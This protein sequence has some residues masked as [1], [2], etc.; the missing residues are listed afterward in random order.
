MLLNKDLLELYGF[1]LSIIGALFGL[2]KWVISYR[3]EASLKRK[4][5]ENVLKAEKLA[6]QIEVLSKEL[7]IEEF[8]DR[9]AIEERLDYFTDYHKANYAHFFVVKNGGDHIT[10]RK[11]CSLTVIYEKHNHGKPPLKNQWQNIHVNKQLTEI[12][13]HSLLNGYYYVHNF[14]ENMDDGEMKSHI[15]PMDGMDVAWFYVGKIGIDEYFVSFQFRND[16]VQSSFEIQ[17]IKNYCSNIFFMLKST[18]QKREEMIRMIQKKK[19][20]EDEL[21]EYKLNKN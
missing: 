10:A 3:R 17:T 4:N 1:I 7:I 14:M 13:L 2:Y 11:S 21:L 16:G 19:N 9:L 5:V 12:L 18:H 6:L 20:L 8:K 15:N